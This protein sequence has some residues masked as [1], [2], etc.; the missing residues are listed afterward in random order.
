MY[1]QYLGTII[2]ALT[3]L[4]LGCW[5]PQMLQQKKNGQYTGCLNYMWVALLALVVG[6]LACYLM[7]ST[8]AGKE[9][10]K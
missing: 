5:N 10:M 3:V 6:V 7:H 4:V 8:K 1:G 9:M 2:A